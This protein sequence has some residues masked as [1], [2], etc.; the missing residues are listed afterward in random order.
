MPLGAHQQC[1]PARGLD[2][3]K[4]PQLG[5]RGSPG[6]RTQGDQLHPDEPATPSLSFLAM[7]IIFGVCAGGG[8][9][10]A[11]LL[12]YLIGVQRVG[13]YWWMWN[14]SARVDWVSV[15]SVIM[16]RAVGRPLVPSW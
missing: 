14:R 9:F 3:Q 13:A 4:G 6:E 11:P 12:Y 10:S 15:I 7:K 8:W 5:V 1:P 16:R 2:R